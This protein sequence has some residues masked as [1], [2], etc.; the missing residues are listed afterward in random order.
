MDGFSYKLL[1]LCNG[2][3]LGDFLNYFIGKFRKETAADTF[4][5]NFECSFFSSEIFCMILIREC[6]VYV[7]VITGVL[8][9]S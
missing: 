3:A 7:Y 5:R 1:K 6:N 2:L 9:I 4:Y 8:P